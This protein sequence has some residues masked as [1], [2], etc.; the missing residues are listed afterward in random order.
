MKG[1]QRARSR[2]MAPITSIRKKS[3]SRLTLIDTLETHWLYGTT[4]LQPQLWL[5]G[6][7]P[8]KIERQKRKLAI[9]AA[10]RLQALVRSSQTR[11]LVVTGVKLIPSQE[12]QGKEAAAATRLQALVRA[13]Q[14]RR[15][16]HRKR[17]Y[18]GQGE[19]RL[20]R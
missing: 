2:P 6:G 16:R 15:R 17:G 8:G 7:V 10:T 3:A 12:Q 9:E 13:H 4:L 1:E 14:A 19:L 5:K 18:R 20:P 11:R